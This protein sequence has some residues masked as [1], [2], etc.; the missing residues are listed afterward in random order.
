[1]NLVSAEE[2]AKLTKI[3]DDYTGADNDEFMH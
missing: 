1:L 2:D 3:F